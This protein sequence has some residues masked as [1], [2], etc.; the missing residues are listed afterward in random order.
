MHGEGAED[1][2][3]SHGRAAVVG[4]VAEGIGEGLGPARDFLGV[5]EIRRDVSAAHGADDAAVPHVA[6]GLV[7]P[8]GVG[9]EGDVGAAM[10]SPLR[11]AGGFAGS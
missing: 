4:D 1:A 6:A 5:L 11:S 3:V 9:L 7:H 8:K 10:K 2:G